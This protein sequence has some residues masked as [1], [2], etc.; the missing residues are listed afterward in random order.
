MR[1]NMERNTYRTRGIE[2][3]SKLTATRPKG[4][5]VRSP[6][7]NAGEIEHIEIE[8]QRRGTPVSQ[9]ELV[10]HLRRSFFCGDVIPASRP[11]LLTA[12]PS[13]LLYYSINA[14]FETVSFVI[15]RKD[16]DL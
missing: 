3:F 6:G 4:P 13:G 8:R 7:R 15:S 2:V 16:G 10:P 12:G 5:A 14:S 1:N 11:G 9:M